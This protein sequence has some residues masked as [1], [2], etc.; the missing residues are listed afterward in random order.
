LRSSKCA[1]RSAATLGDARLGAHHLLQRGPAALEL[2]LLALFFV[3]GQFVD[4]VVDGGHL[5]G[6]QAQLGE[7]A[8]VVD[9]HGG[10]I[11][12]GLLHVVDADVVAEHRA[13][14]AVFARHRRAG[15]GHE[16]GVG[17]RVAQVLGVAHLVLRGRRELGTVRG[18][19][20]SPVVSRRCPRR[21]SAS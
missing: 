19:W 15:E 8:L 13:R 9:G 10:A 14:V 3:F 17:Q 16:G 1:T 11:F 4:L 18:R 12:L 20:P 5:V 6:L 7:P 21:P 2:G